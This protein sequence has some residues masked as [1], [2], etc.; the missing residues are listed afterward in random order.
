MK[1]LLMIVLAIGISATAAFGQSA[2]PKPGPEQSRLGFFIGEWRFGSGGDFSGT[3]T[4]SWFSGGF[5]VVCI[6]ETIRG[7]KGQSIWAYD[8]SRQ[9]YTLYEFN[10]LGGGS[11]VTPTLQDHTWTWNTE[12]KEGD[13]VVR[14][15][16]TLTEESPTS[17]LLKV[18]RSDG[19]PWVV[20]EGGRSTKVR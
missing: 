8:P 15:R 20:F 18:E 10:N 2:I 19:G 12:M 17:Q 3:R 9:T 11:F 14:W 5:Q 16:T 1:Q 7:F 6:A 4:C 13:K